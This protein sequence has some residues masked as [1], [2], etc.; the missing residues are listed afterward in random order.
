M[1]KILADFGVQPVYLAAQV[2]NFIVL[3]LILK[4]FLYRPILKVL[5][6]RKKTVSESLINAEQIEV[7]LQV[8]EQESAKK[9][10]E[11]SKQAKMILDNASNTANQII[12]DAHEKAKA[13]IESMIEKGKENI[14]VER[15]M[16]KKEMSEELAGLVLLGVE[17]IAGKALDQ[18]DHMKIFDQTIE[19]LKRGVP[20][21]IL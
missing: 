21:K 15:E 20:T 10:S 18:P 6:D 17:R 11:V 12:A 3:L 19:G 2:V 7:Q 5:E 13:D 9:L 16:M 1:D 8:T 14:I 4:K